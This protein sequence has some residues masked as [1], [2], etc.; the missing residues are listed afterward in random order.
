MQGTENAF[1]ELR[2]VSVCTK[3]LDLITHKD[4]HVILML[5]G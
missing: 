1:S 3:T 4:F 5:I 2:H